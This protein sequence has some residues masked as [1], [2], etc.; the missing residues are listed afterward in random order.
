ML[1]VNPKVQQEILCNYIKN[2]VYTTN[3]VR[4]ILGFNKIEGA[5]ILTY[6]S[7]QVTLENIISGEASWLKGGEKNGKTTEGN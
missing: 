7:G 3:D 6:P 4:E 1:R 2:G 5:D